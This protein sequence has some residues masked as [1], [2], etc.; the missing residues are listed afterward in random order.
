MEK[1]NLIALIVFSF[2]A[3]SNAANIEALKSL[4]FANLNFEKMA[5]VEVAPVKTAAPAKLIKGYSNT[6]LVTQDLIYK[7]TRVANDLRRLRLNTAG[8]TN[9]VKRLQSEARIIASSGKTDPFFQNNLRKM[10]YDINKHLTAAE[11]IRRD[12]RQLL[13][14]TVKSDKLHSLAKNMEWESRTIHSSAQFGLQ[15]AA[16]NLLRTVRSAKPEIIGF[17]AQSTAS[18]I[19]RNLRTYSS[20]VK[21]IHYS[22]TPLL[23]KT[24]L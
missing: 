16:T 1:I 23:L 7:F 8:L 12:M 24:L 17:T 10:S 13:H 4:N 11:R 20:K 5:E 21:D 14:I 15:N 9:D 6:E 19:T 18:E 2:S 3:I 22:V